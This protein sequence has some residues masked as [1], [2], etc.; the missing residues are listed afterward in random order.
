MH[1]QEDVSKGLDGL[2]RDQEFSGTLAIAASR[3]QA[4][5]SDRTVLDL[6]TYLDAV[7]DFCRRY[8]AFPSEHEPVAVALWVAHAHLVELFDTSPVLSV[9]S[10][11]MRSGKTRVLE[12]LE[13]LVPLPLPCVQPSEAVVYTVLAERPRRTILLDEADAIFGS[14]TAERNEGL[15]AILNAGNRRG[16]KIPRVRWKGKRREVEYFEI[17]GPK[18]IAGIGNLPDTIADRAISIRMKRRAAHEKVAKFRRRQ[19]VQEANGIVLDRGRVPVVPVVPVPED[20]NDRA[21]DSWEPLIAVAQA[22]GGFWPERG[23][24]AA[25]ALSGRDDRPISVGM[26]L[27][28]D[29]R[30]AFAAAEYLTTNELLEKL[31]RLDDAPWGDWYGSPLTAHRL[32]T[33]LRPYGVG[34]VQGRVHG[35]KS[36]GYFRTHFLDPWERYLPPLRAGTSGTSGT[37]SSEEQSPW[38]CSVGS[39][40]KLSHRLDGSPVCGTCHPSRPSAAVRRSS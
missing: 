25:L 3:A 29:I 37:G 24:R 21:A 18:V 13:L 35:D 7:T 16:A 1:L 33:L 30:D 6:A 10:A 22:A 12:V 32:A 27:L 14:R 4:Q 5:V 9:T 31:H 20:L 17:Y 8:I 40:H 38:R 36:R 2:G 39:G 15:R 26:R 28:T 34:P 11:E 19:A 23:W